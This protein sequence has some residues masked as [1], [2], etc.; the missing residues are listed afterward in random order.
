MLKTPAGLRAWLPLL[1]FTERALEKR[2][3]LTASSG[4]R[5]F[6]VDDEPVIAFTLAAILQMHGFSAKFF[7]SPLEALAAAK[8]K[9]PDLL[10]SDV[11]MADLSGIDLAIQMKAQYPTCKILLFSGR[12]STFDLLD[13]A[14]AQGHDFDLLLKPVLPLDFLSEISKRIGPSEGRKSNFPTAGPLELAA[15]G[16][17]RMTRMEQTVVPSNVKL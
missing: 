9:S 10:I 14:R 13:S 7:T 16:E 17:S 8:A 6:V 15:A 4:P 3:N 12:P 5:V 11:E 2:K 1:P